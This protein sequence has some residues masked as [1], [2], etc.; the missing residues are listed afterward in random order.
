MDKTFAS[1][2]GRATAIIIAI[3]MILTCVPMMNPVHAASYPYDSLKERTAA[4][5]KMYKLANSEHRSSTVLKRYQDKTLK[6]MYETKEKGMTSTQTKYIKTKANTII[7]ERKKDLKKKKLTEYEEVRAFHDWIINHFYYYADVN[8]ISSNCDN[9][10]YLL[11]TEY[12]NSAK[13]GYGKIRSRCNG[14]SAT[15]IAF[16][17]SQGIP[18]RAVDGTYN[19]AA[20]VT[21]TGNFYKKSKISITHHWTQVYVDSNRDGK[22]EWINIDCNADCW[23]NYSPSKGYVKSGNFYNKTKYKA[24]RKAYFNPTAKRLAQSHVII[25][26]RAG[27]K[28]VKYLSNK[29]EAKQLKAFL[30]TKY[31]GKTNGKRINSSYKTTSPA[32]WFPKSG[33]KSL[34]DGNGNLY[35][36][37]LPAEKSLYGKLDLSNFKALQ[38]VECNKND[39]T[40]L[41]IKNCP[42]LSTVAA[43]NNELTVID[44]TGSKN[45]KLLSVQ[46]NPTV[47]VKYSFNKKRN[48]VIEASDPNG[49][50]ISVRYSLNGSKHKHEMK[51]IAKK[52]YKFVGWYNGETLISNEAAIVKTLSTS[53]AYTAVFVPR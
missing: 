43:S 5:Q 25:E 48:A 18:A 35:K 38:N 41:Y 27:S 53:F 40:E 42:K 33:N 10:Y 22:K 1:L 31:N 9:P 37:Y 51:A 26:Y 11:T 2:K 14:Y 34:G 20:R 32:T 8:K 36:L 4:N 49:G 30:N 3:A 6:D 15:L 45:I 46:G 52:G 23:N 44:T 21:N 12:K 24:V 28:D 13:K 7:K 19:T 29:T 50:T 17:R 47:R 16:A 39:L